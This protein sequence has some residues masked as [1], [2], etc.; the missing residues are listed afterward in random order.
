VAKDY[1]SWEKKTAPSRNKK[2]RGG[3]WLR[4]LGC[5]LLVCLVLLLAGVIAA[6]IGW[7]K[8]AVPY[9]VKADA[10]D[11][12]EMERMETASFLYDREGK[13]MGKIYLQDRV[14]V[15]WDEISPNMI[16]AV[17]AVEDNYF[18][19]H[20]GINF[21]GIM[22]ALLANWQNRAIQQ[23]ASTVTQQLA[24]NTFDL[25]DKSMERKIVETLL[26]LRIERQFSKQDIMRLYLNRVYFGSGFYGVESAALGYF[27]K[28][29]KDL[30]VGEAAT[31][32][33][34]LKSP[35]NFSPLNNLA[36][37][38]NQRNVALRR[39]YERGFIDDAT[40][41]AEI[42]APLVVRDR[43][44]SGRV[45]YA[46]DAA[47]QHVIN[48]LGYE[49]AMNGGF[50]IYTTFDTALQRAA[51]D[52]LAETLKKVET[53]QQNSPQGYNHITYDQFREKVRALS[54]ADKFP[55]PRYLQGALVAMDSRTGA[56]LALVGGR[57]Y[58]HSEYNRVLAARRPAGT[59]FKPIVFA[60]AF[61]AG[62]FPGETVDDASM[63]NRYVMIGGDSG[64][65]GEWGV[66]TADNDYE[67]SITMHKA[68]AKGKNAATVRAGLRVGITRMKETAA[69]LGIVS[70]IRD[71][72]G[73][74]LGS[75]EVTL[76]ELTLA[77]TPFGQGGMRPV[78]PHLLTRIV[79]A[80]GAT[81]YE[82]NFQTMRAISPE[83]AFQVHHALTDALHQGTGAI[84]IEEYG[85]KDF[86]AAGKTGTAYGFTDTYFI[87]YN[88]S[89]T[90]GVWVGF[91]KPTPI[92]RGAF[93]K[94]LALPVWVRVMNSAARIF[95][96]EKFTKPDTL[97]EVEIC[98]NSGLLATPQCGERSQE[99]G[100]R[101]QHAGASGDEPSEGT[102]GAKGSTGVP[103]VVASVSLATPA[104][105]HPTYLTTSEA[106]VSTP[107]IPSIPRD[108]APLPSAPTLTYI[109]LA[110]EKQMPKM[111]CDV[112]GGGI[113]DYTKH[114]AESEWPRPVLAVNLALIKPIAID[115][116]ALIGLAD[117]YQS[118]RPGGTDNIP[119]QRAILIEEEKEKDEEGSK[120]EEADAK[121][122]APSATP[123]PT[124]PEPPAPAYTP[125]YLKQLFLQ[126]R[127]SQTPAPASE[128][129]EDGIPVRR[130]LP[131]T[132]V[133]PI[134][135]F[136][137]NREL[138]IP[139]HVGAPLLVTIPDPARTPTENLEDGV[140]VR[141]ALP[142][143]PDSP[144]TT[145]PL[146]PITPSTED[147]IPVHRA[148]PATPDS[149]SQP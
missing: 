65:L 88:S 105:P 61:E 127:E 77:Y 130:A 32:A 87:G 20:R 5:F 24:R 54:A 23:G 89:V 94:N 60:A 50:S 22:R 96:T 13:L 148:L 58:R 41:A 135:P 141:R 117:I 85:L 79:D 44:D 18:Y 115:S 106:S 132:P 39:M 21:R 100:V 59:A 142:A 147:G 126:T 28:S 17:I 90:C 6:W 51:E 63:D 52:A 29:A 47:R 109:E 118:V 26:A 110:T 66:E 11:L 112:H 82:T 143:T 57:D 128:T 71:Y 25:F 27:G 38:T 86:P 12:A 134:P 15:A 97:R 137:Q 3:C 35:Q 139:R 40:R 4:L 121:D 138:K 84:A 10:F 125:D 48:A 53:S 16:N 116:P 49:R 9:V 146:V 19:E 113:R 107:S 7:Q 103:P 81:I 98:I 2:R 101:S 45:S 122:D 114:F 43:R 80:S 33:G 8:F 83:A 129:T 145:E 99:S 64:I 136:S 123:A 140:P 68:L 74:F 56:V 34:L 144:I 93:G 1:Y 42:A 119:V 149:T 14:P 92:F 62:M 37:S 104:V 69:A 133:F 76:P 36:A 73:S 108:G 55:D 46:V 78:E 72:A 75:S 124:A 67:G 70:P 120:K 111:L 30:S 95:P 131:V 91:D 31:L 102:E